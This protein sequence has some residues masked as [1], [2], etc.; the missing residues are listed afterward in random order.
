[1]TLIVWTD[2]AAE[3]CQTDGPLDLFLHVIEALNNSLCTVDG[4]RDT[5]V[6]DD[7]KLPQE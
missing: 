5:T 1:M 2:E 3:S 7:Q 4:T 6:H